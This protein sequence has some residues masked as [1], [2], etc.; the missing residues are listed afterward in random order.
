VLDED[1]DEKPPATSPYL[2]PDHEEE[3]VSV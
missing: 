2:V 3:T 1:A